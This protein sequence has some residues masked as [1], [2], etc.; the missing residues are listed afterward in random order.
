MIGDYG[1]ALPAHHDETPCTGGTVVWRS[2]VRARSCSR[3]ATSREHAWQPPGA[4]VL[5]ACHW[6]CT[7]QPT[8]V[9]K[10]GL[11]RRTAKIDVAANTDTRRRSAILRAGD[12]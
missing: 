1:R 6:R 4:A 7:T 9:E 12:T 5:R 11:P 8:L 10:T 2:T 3:C